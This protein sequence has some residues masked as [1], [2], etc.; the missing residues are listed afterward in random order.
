MFSLLKQRLRAVPKTV[1]T[2]RDELSALQHE[3]ELQ[4]RAPPPQAAPPR[5]AVAL[6][7]CAAR[8]A[9]GGRDQGGGAHGAALHQGAS[10]MS[11]LSPRRAHR[12]GAQGEVDA[13]AVAARQEE[14]ARFAARLREGTPRAST[15]LIVPHSPA[16]PDAGIELIKHGRRGSPHRRTFVLRG[17][18]LEWK[19]GKRSVALEAVS[20]VVP[21]RVT[22]ELKRGTGADAEDCCL[23][24]QTPSYSLNLQV[25]VAAAASSRLRARADKVPAAK[26]ESKSARNDLL[27]GFKALLPR[28]GWHET[29]SDA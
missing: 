26:A 21:G 23:V 6:S 16:C 9:A 19:D 4:A 25:R 12:S 27:R 14:K 1:D 17:E 15:R 10:P 8:A 13:R 20:A 5:A 29:P 24:V 22:D 7:T 3:L 2:S 28:L 11:P 18:R